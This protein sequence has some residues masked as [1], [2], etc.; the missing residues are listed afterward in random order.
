MD[1]FDQSFLFFGKSVPKNINQ[2]LKD[3]FE[4]QNEE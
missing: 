3:T 4:I 2:T 1:S